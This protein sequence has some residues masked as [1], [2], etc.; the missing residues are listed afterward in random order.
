M[1][2]NTTSAPPAIEFEDERSFLERHNDH[3]R[4]VLTPNRVKADRVTGFRGAS[5]ASA[6]TGGVFRRCGL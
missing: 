6:G 4:S 2:P 3:L 1:A 5:G